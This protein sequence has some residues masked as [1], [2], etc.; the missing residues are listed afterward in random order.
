MI[1]PAHHVAACTLSTTS[2]DL[3]FKW[4]CKETPEPSRYC[5]DGRSQCEMMCWCDSRNYFSERDRRR[6]QFLAWRLAVLKRNLG[7]PNTRF[8]GVVVLP[9]RHTTAADDAFFAFVSSPSRRQMHLAAPVLSGTATELAEDSEATVINS[10]HEETHEGETDDDL[11][12]PFSPPPRAVA[13]APRELASSPLLAFQA[14]RLR[15]YADACLGAVDAK[16]AAAPTQSSSSAVELVAAGIASQAAGIVKI[17]REARVPK[18]GR[19]TLAGTIC[20]TTISVLKLAGVSSYRLFQLATKSER[21][22]LTVGL[23]FVFRSQLRSIYKW[24]L[25]AVYQWLGAAQAF[26][27]YCTQFFSL[28]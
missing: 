8:P 4:A 1:T 25:A 18:S 20:K 5:P 3:W 28:Y 27:L 21:L 16:L 9:P 2:A 26:Q 14:N 10:T 22:A 12:V 15:E 13:A 23:A 17:E 7:L 11:P 6:T 24:G 19:T